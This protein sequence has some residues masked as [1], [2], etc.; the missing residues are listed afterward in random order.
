[1]KTFRALRTLVL[2]IAA[3]SPRKAILCIAVMGAMSVTEGVGLLV[4]MP[5][6]ELV[7]FNQPNSMPTVTGWFRFAFALVGMQPTLGNVLLLFMGIVGVRSLFQRWQTNLVTSLR[8][9]FVSALRVRV[10]EAIAGAEWKFLTTRRSSDFTYVMADEIGRIGNAASQLIDLAVLL[11]LSV[12]Y[13]GLAIHFS[14]TMAALVLGG[15]GILAWLM[16][17]RLDDARRFG[18]E[19]STARRQ[20][21]TAIAE[22]MGSMKI[23]KSYGI[24]ARHMEIFTR[25]SRDV[26]DRSLDVTAGETDLQQ[27]LEFGSMAFLSVIVYVSF[28]LLDVPPT[29]L[30]V[31]LLLFSRLMPRLALIYRRVQALMSAIP[32]LDHVMAIETD[33]RAAAEEVRAEVALPPLVKSITFEKMSF[34]YSHR[35]DTYALRHLDFEIPVGLTTAI[36]SPS[37]GGKSTLADLLVG[38]LVPS[39]GRLLVDGIPLGPEFLPAWRRIIAYVPQDTF[40]FHDS[41]RTNLSWARQEATDDELWEGLRMA[42]AATFVAALPKGLD[43]IIG[44]RGV[45]LS[46]GERQRLA[47]ARALL[48]RPQVLV[49]DEAT[50]ALDSENELQIQ[51]AIEGLHKQMTI[52]VITHRLSTIRQ[53][54][55]VHVLDNGSLVESGT[56][57]ALYDREG[58]RFR[59]LCLAQGINERA[60]RSE[61]FAGTSS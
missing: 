45:L 50:S 16:S 29:Q 15:A 21:H 10:Y 20:L 9:D 26:R 36:V 53:A 37:G 58:G 38:L 27:N 6:L 24:A 61:S 42:A 32:V 25:L 39:E 57:D 40:L 31:L 41:I 14:P 35:A 7:G 33:C 19:A 12:V 52:V 2:E 30:L 34:A 8:E 49:L 46:G 22:H 51:R 54:D 3:D 44:E 47:L 4:L 60:P 48:R 18:A 43:T 59:S 56:W 5:L 28:E 55:M 23:A 11:A 13:L 17:H 1:M